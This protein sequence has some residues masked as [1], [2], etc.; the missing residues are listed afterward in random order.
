MKKNKPQKTGFFWYPA[1][2]ALAGLAA[3]QVIAVVFIHL[4]NLDLLAKITVLAEA[5]YL[6]VPNARV[7]PSLNHWGP[8]WWGGVFFT[9]STGAGLAAA[10]L[11][12]VWVWDRLFRRSGL[13][14][15][16]LA[17]I[18]L[19]GPVVLAIAGFDPFLFCLLLLVPPAS[20]ITAARLMPQP[21][22]RE[23]WWFRL[24]FLA[25]LILMSLI[26]VSLAGRD[27]FSDLRDYL[28]WN[29]AAGRSLSDFYYKYTLY[30]AETFKTLEQKT[31]KTC[32]LPSA[33][34]GDPNLTADLENA[35][36]ARDYLPLP[37]GRPVELELALAGGDLIMSARGVEVMTVAAK[38]FIKKPDQALSRFSGLTDRRKPLR[39]ATIISLLTA[40]PL[41]PYLIIFYLLTLVVSIW[42]PP[43]RAAAAAGLVALILGVSLMIPVISGRAPPGDDDDPGRLLAADDW[44]VRAKA[45]RRITKQ[46]QEI[47]G[48]KGYEK[49]IDS[50]RIRERYWLAGALGV[51]RSHETY[52]L[53]MKMLDDPQIN[54]VCFALLGLGQRGDRPAVRRILKL[55][56]ESDHWYIQWYAYRALKAL[57]WRQKRSP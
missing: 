29:T 4:S 47:A 1:V 33:P 15:A 38:D 31:L 9:F 36:L 49:S 28:L 48:F 26:W 19:A 5:G 11:I 54:V 8:A 22:G 13:V 44:R 2:A 39:R 56:E 55:I 3:T 42:L 6:I 57:H 21:A 41:I 23:A 17:L 30:P 16:V 51:S 27:V 40:G 46:E 14:L 24:A 10:G 18:W 45:L 43:R 25:P 32:R 53:L 34:S 37:P 52:P 12:A 20:F 35:L 7:L 50:D